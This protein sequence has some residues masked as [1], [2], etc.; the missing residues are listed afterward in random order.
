MSIPAPDPVTIGFVGACA[1]TCGLLVGGVFECVP[2]RWRERSATATFWASVVGGIVGLVL[3]LL[4]L[5]GV[6]SQAG[7]FLPKQTDAFTFVTAMT[8][9][10]VLV[11]GIVLLYLGYVRDLDVDPAQW[12]KRAA[13]GWFVIAALV[14]ALAPSLHS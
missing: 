9:L 2:R 5:C 14:Y 13:L 10:G 1:G 11:S 4:A 12:S 3:W 6:I 8:G 7:Y